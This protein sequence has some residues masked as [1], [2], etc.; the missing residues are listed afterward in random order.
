MPFLSFIPPDRLA[1]FTW[2]YAFA[3]FFG[4]IGGAVAFGG[5]YSK[6]YDGDEML[7]NFEWRRGT[8]SGVRMRNATRAEVYGHSH[9]DRS[10]MASWKRSRVAG[11]AA[12]LLLFF[13]FALV[14]PQMA[15]DEKNFPGHLWAED[16]RF[17]TNRINLSILIPTAVITL[18]ALIVGSRITFGAFRMYGLKRREKSKVYSDQL[19][20]ADRACLGLSRTD[21]IISYVGMILL[22]LPIGLAIMTLVRTSD[23][24]ALPD[25]YHNGV[26]LYWLAGAS[27]PYLLWAIVQS[28]MRM[29]KSKKR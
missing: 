11:C 10:Y 8:G 16:H 22:I 15:G 25:Y 1:Y 7:P 3:L 9:K 20:D 12:Y 26:L 23:T 24:A 17:L 6:S 2:L 27:L 19:T 21:S 14:L 4:L 5:Y 13:I 28:I 29:A 18:L